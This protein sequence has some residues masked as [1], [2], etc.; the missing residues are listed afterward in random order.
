M[1]K[2]SLGLRL[3][4][5]KVTVAIIRQLKLDTSVPPV[6]QFFRGGT[7]AAEKIFA[8]FLQTK[9]GDYREHRNQPQTSD[10]SHMSKYLHF[11][12]ISPAWLAREAR[13][14]NPPGARTFA[15]SLMS[16]SSAG[17]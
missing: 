17:N 15:A 13:K 16:C 2:S 12:Q 6:T 9:F 11:G 8:H 14:K 3:G 5:E 4:G 7:K 1:K 10:V